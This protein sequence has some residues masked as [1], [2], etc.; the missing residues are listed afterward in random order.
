M[1]MSAPDKRFPSSALLACAL[2]SGLLLAGPG[3]GAAAAAEVINDPVFL[4]DYD[5]SYAH[6]D[7]IDSKELLPAC[8]AG[9]AHIKPLPPTLPL[10]ARLVTA[11]ARIFVAG[12]Q[13]N[14]RVF[15]IRNGQCEAGD[16][17]LTLLG[18]EAPVLSGA[19]SSGVFND[20]LSRYA[21]AFGGKKRF[22]EWLDTWTEDVRSHCPGREDLC[23]PTYYAYSK[24]LQEL[25]ARFRKD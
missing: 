1:N 16:T 13:D 25:I 8:K 7:T 2:W 3:H 22:F 19:E 17:R 10:Y 9:L 15:V 23:Y 14:V 21:Q 11:S 12:T 24:D 20:A 4:I 5:P 18:K 6:F